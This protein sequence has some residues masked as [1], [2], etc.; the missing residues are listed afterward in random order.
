LGELSLRSLGVLNAPHLGADPCQV[1]A[2]PD[3]HLRGHALDFGHSPQQDV[4]ATDVTAAEPQS[5]PPRQLQHASRTRGKRGMA[6]DYA[7]TKAD[8]LLN[9]LADRFEVEAELPERPG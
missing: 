3:E 8:D 6:G 1:R 9:L 4:L 5:F 2:H 7:R